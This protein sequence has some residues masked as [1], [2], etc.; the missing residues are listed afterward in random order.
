MKIRNGFTLIELI[1]VVVII[2]I[3][4]ALALPSYQ[5][6][7]TRTRIKEA[8]ANLVGLSLSVE[9]AYQRSL[10]YPAIT[11]NKSA[12][13]SG[14]SVLNTWKAT[15]DKFEYKYESSAGTD[16]TLTATGVDSRVTGCTLT[17]K[18]DGTKTISG[19]GSVTAWVN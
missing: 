4:A 19:C 11:L 18:N 1:V 5:S 7:I 15:S 10:S 2:G 6:Y 12:L 13:I 8:Q 16:Y 9:N 17:L 14:N 3:L